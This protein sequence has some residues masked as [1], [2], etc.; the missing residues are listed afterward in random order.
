MGIARG[1]SEI[2]FRDF[3]VGAEPRLRRGLVAGFGVQVAEEATA[4]AIAYAWEHWDRLRDMDNP[5]GYL[6]RVGQTSGR[7][8]TRPLA[9]VMFTPET[10]SEH[11]VEPGLPAAVAS[12]SESQRICTLLVHGAGW[13]LSEVGELLSVHPGTV[14]KHAERG[15]DKLRS[16]LGVAADA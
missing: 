9:P 15:L 5:V 14:A 1:S 6:Y 3:M 10:S 11:A 13:T 4:D 8:S 16:E 12:L 2:E 7:R